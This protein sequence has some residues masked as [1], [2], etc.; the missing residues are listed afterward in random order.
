MTYLELELSTERRWWIAGDLP[1]TQRDTCSF[2]TTYTPFTRLIVGRRRPT[3][4][5]VA[6]LQSVCVNGSSVDLVLLSDLYS[7]LTIL[8]F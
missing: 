4:Q 1:A 8:S 5:A 7:V 2:K 6:W 3:L